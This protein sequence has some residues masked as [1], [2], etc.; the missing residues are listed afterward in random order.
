MRSTGKERDQLIVPV[1]VLRQAGIK[2][3]DRLQFKASRRTITI[4]AVEEP[5]YK[6]AKAELAAINKGEAQI[7]RGRFVALPELLHE[8]DSHRRGSGAKATRKVSR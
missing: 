2:S 4:T 7:A 3:T 6:P 5:R 1:S 8:L